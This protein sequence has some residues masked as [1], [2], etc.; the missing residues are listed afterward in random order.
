MHMVVEQVS[1]WTDQLIALGTDM[2]KGHIEPA[3]HIR[4]LPRAIDQGDFCL[5][6]VQ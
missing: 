3:R 2:V 1:L 4:M 6:A 5:L